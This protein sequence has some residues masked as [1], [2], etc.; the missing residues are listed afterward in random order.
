MKKTFA[1]IASIC[2]FASAQGEQVLNLLT[3][4]V[5]EGGNA[6]SPTC[7]ISTLDD[8]YQVTWEFTEARLVEDREFENTILWF[9]PDF[10]Q[11][12]IAGEPCISCEYDW[13]L[14]G[15]ATPTLEVVDSSFVDY[16][17]QLAPAFP[18]QPGG[19]PLYEKVERIPINPYEGFFPTHII[20]ETG[21]YSY[22]ESREVAYAIYPIQYNYEQQIV[23][24]Y[25]KIVYKVTLSDSTTGIEE[26]K[27]KE[28]MPTNSFSLDG[29]PI[30]GNA[31]SVIIR[32]GKKL[33]IE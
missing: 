31:K 25:T 33:I 27:T 11:I 23:R 18:L 17:Y 15:N 16:N 12:H 22:S 3:G 7:S 30:K 5:R 2:L 24:A 20:K 14:I 26:L 28:D 1:F 21:F 6:A 4:E 32:D 29:R 19:T 8:G 13:L 9:F 10:R